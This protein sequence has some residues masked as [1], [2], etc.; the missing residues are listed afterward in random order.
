MYFTINLKIEVLS[1][2]TVKLTNNRENGR[3][4]LLDAQRFYELLKTRG[5]G[6]RIP[7]KSDGYEQL[8]FNIDRLHIS[9]SGGGVNTY[10]DPHDYKLLMQELEALIKQNYKES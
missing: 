4:Y 8:S 6:W 2:N 7:N 10:I 1:D 5:K 3:I 9:S